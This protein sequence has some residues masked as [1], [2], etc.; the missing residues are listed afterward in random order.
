MVERTL[1]GAHYGLGDW[2]IQRVSAVIMVIYTVA[3]TV[4]LCTMPLEYSTWQVFFA[5]TWVRIFTQITFIAVAL[6]AWVGIRDLWMDYVKC[7]YLRLTL[8]VGAIVW[9][10][11]CFIYSI[12]V[13]WGL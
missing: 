12:K 5:Q 2:M 1:V 10:L 11:A 13:V 3:M 6:H 4:F 9:L 7:A 8:H